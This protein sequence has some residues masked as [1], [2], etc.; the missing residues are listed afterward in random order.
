[1]IPKTIVAPI[2]PFDLATLRLHARIPLISGAHPEDPLLP[3]YAR[4]ARNHVQSYCNMS[5]GRQTLEVALDQFPIGGIMLPRGPAAE[6]VSISYIDPDSATITLDPSAYAI[7]TYS[8]KHWALPAY[9]T[10]WPEAL[11]AANAVKVR[12]LAGEETLPEEAQAAILL[13]FTHLYDNRSASI[14]VALKEIPLGV[15]ALMD[16][17]RVYGD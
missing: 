11:C 1:M 13:L 6:I 16:M 3:I 17:I 7:D 10:D 5:L 2:D 9:G 12:Y 4:A 15:I 14:E 8:P